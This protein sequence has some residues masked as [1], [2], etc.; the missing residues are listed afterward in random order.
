MPSQRKRKK[1]TAHA[2]EVAPRSKAGRRRCMAA[3]LP[4][5]AVIHRLE[6]WLWKCGKKKTLQRA[7]IFAI[8]AFHIP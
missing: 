2:K 3:I 8:A 4:R 7:E 1:K 5:V 6:D